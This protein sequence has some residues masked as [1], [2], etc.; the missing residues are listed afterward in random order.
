MRW[1]TVQVTSTLD[2][3]LGCE[4][5]LEPEP[6]LVGEE[7]RGASC[8]RRIFEEPFGRAWPPA[9]HA[10]RSKGNLEEFQQYETVDLGPAGGFLL[11]PYVTKRTTCQARRL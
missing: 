7:L 6:L 10:L 8:A 3:L 1:W 2:V 5:G 11:S 9:E 4:Q